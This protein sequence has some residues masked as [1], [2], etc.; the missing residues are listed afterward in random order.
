MTSDMAFEC[1]LISRDPGV[2]CTLSPL[3]DKLAIST[4]LCLSPSKAEIEMKEGSADLIVIDWQ[5]D[6]SAAE[7]LRQIQVSN[8]NRKKTVVLVSPVDRTFPGAHLVVRKPVT[9]ESG[10]DALKFVYSRMLRD[11]RRHARYA[12]M[13]PVLATSNENRLLPATITNVGDGGVGL[14]T[15]ETI[16]IGDALS[17]RLW[18]P[19]T[20]RAIYIEAR[21]LW[22]REY[23]VYGCE[24]LRIP[25][26]DLDI[27][28]DWLKQKCRI[29]RPRVAF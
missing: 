8:S 22:S 14:S 21:V 2:V 11:H 13:I 28:N 9:P 12:V 25:P 5:E 26:V 24:F 16:A 23:G 20:R 17:F 19:N 6:G 27:L 1:L 15:K 18:L 7:L 29:K 10:A 4:K 3:L